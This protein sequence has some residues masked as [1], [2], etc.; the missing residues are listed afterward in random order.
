VQSLSSDEELKDFLFSGYFANATP[1]ERYTMKTKGLIQ[2]YT[3]D[4]KGKTTAAIG[5]ACRARG[6]DLKVCYLYFHKDP[7]KWGYGEYRVLKKI[8]IMIKGFAQ[9][10]PHFNKNMDKEEIRIE[11]LNGVQFIKEM[12]QENRYDIL[13]LDEILIS[14]RDGFIKEEELLEILHSKPAGLELVLTGRGATEKLIEK[15]NLV[16]EIRE[17][18]HPYQA[19]IESREGIEY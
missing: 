15:A 12:Y 19:G 10:H 9:H 8:G 3:G 4:G 7:V 1:C 17:I 6:H 18:K 13:I 2:I 5:L 14:L 11:C 16:S